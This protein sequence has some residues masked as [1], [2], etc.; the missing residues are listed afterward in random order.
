MLKIYRGIP[1]KTYIPKQG[2]RGPAKCSLW[3]R[4]GCGYSSSILDFLEQLVG[5]QAYNIVFKVP[6][7]AQLQK[8]EVGRAVA[9]AATVPRPFFCI[10]FT[11]VVYHALG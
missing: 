6:A 5:E 10:G 9:I 4:H 1:A 7:Q 8:V 11:N 3:Y 2:T